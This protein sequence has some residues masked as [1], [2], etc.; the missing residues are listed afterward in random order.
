ML[1]TVD[2]V[3]PCEDEDDLCLTDSFANAWREEC[4]RLRDVDARQDAL[5][6]LFETD[7]IRVQLGGGQASV[8]DG[9]SRLAVWPSTSALVADFAADRVLTSRAPDWG[10]LA[11]ERRF[12]ILAG[13]RTFLETCPLCDGP[14]ELGEQT[15]DSC[16]RS[17]EVLSVH[18][19][20]CDA[21]LL[22]LDPET[23]ETVA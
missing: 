22:E 17:W 4:R 21:G 6:D 12:G 10:V 13:L 3:E 20:A 15:V 2:T 16:C 19:T 5:S 1:S 18:C 8:S 9:D 7:T 14:V 23:L 11:P